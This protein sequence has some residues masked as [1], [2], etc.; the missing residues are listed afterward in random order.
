MNK[1]HSQDVIAGFRNKGH[2]ELYFTGQSRRIRP[3][4]IQKCIRILQVLEIAEQPSEMNMAGYRFH[5]LH[6][7]PPGWPVRVTGNDRI[8]F[9][10]L[11]K[12]AQDVDF[13]DYH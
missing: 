11:G 6:G 1:V 7:N 10:W 13:E 5:G 2:E 3:D 9:A 12:S 4:V 8:T